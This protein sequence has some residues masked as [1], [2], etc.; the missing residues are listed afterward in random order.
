[1][2]LADSIKN[3]VD[4]APLNS[5]CSVKRIAETLSKEDKTT[6]ESALYNRGIKA[7]VLARAFAK[8]KIEI[9]AS[10]ITR[11]RNGGCA[12]CAK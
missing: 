2:S 12:N 8:E 4:E 1:M 7:S 11:H 6:L 10:T 3:A 9:S 5:I